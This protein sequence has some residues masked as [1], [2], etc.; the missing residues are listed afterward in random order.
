MLSNSTKI[1]PEGIFN[2]CISTLLNTKRLPRKTSEATKR[3]S[4]PLRFMSVTAFAKC[5][6]KSIKISKEKLFIATKRT[7]ENAS[8]FLG[9]GHS[10]NARRHAKTATHKQA[11]SGCLLRTFMR[12]SHCFRVHYSMIVV[13]LPEPTVLPPSR[14]A[15]VRPCSQATG[16]ISSI[17]ISTLSPGMHISVPAGRLQTPVTSVVLK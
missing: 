4:I 14:I 3:T 13:T 12:L 10:S 1:V 15:N 16:W 9:H 8:H 7:F 6:H 5:P 11:C 17:V 2:R